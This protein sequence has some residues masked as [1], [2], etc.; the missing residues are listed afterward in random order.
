MTAAFLSPACVA[1]GRIDDGFEDDRRSVGR[2]QGMRIWIVI[3]GQLR[4]FVERH[5]VAF[6][7]GNCQK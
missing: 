2:G 3:N 7:I 6:Q 5:T 4:E 1:P